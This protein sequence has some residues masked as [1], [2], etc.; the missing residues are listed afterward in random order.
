MSDT[1]N[2]N[3]IPDAS[4]ADAFSRGCLV[5][6]TVSA[7]TGR[8]KIPSASVLDR[9]GVDPAFV[10]A[11]K[12]LV[13]KEALAAPTKVG[14]AARAW[15]YDRSLPFPV[16]GAVF[17]PVALIEQVDAKLDEFK[18][19]FDDAANQFARDF[20]SLRE[21]ARTALG[22]L[23]DAGDYPVDV[24]ERFG[25]SWRFVTLA[26]AGATQLVN[27]EIVERERAKFL[28]LMEEARSSAVTALRVK[29]AEVVDHVADKL[30]RDREDG[31]PQVFRDTLVTNAREFFETFGA[32][33]IAGDG[34]IAQLVERAKAAIDGVPDAQALRDDA[35][36]RA[37]VARRFGE[38]QAQLDTMLVDR[39]ERK[40]RF[41][42]GPAQV[43]A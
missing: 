34:Q 4:A 8:V 7:W 3:S 32:L 6:L 21:A 14:A 24:R 27:P 43:A 22:P 19:E 23:F 29:F 33:N 17:V 35:S 30:S 13:D 20:D 26:P 10:G 36:L 39:P 25:F 37:H 2:T 16:P 1:N 15:L 18:F 11:H 40:L 9:P 41:G 5:Q 12:R 42:A 28:N 38:V 31:K